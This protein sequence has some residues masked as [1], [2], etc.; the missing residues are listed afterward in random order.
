MSEEDEHQTKVT[1]NISG[2]ADTVIGVVREL[3]AHVHVYFPERAFLYI[4]FSIFTLAAIVGI[5]LFWNTTKPAFEA[6]SEGETLIIL[7]SF[8]G[9]SKD[10]E[11]D[12]RRILKDPIQNRLNRIQMA[13]GQ[14]LRMEEWTQDA[15]S[16][17]GQAKELGEKYGATLVIWGEYDD[18]IGVRTYIEIIKEV[19]QPDAQLAGVLLPVASLAPSSEQ[20]KEIGRVPLNCLSVD[21]PYQADYLTTLS[22]G[23]LQVARHE[24][25][26]AI[27][28]FSES[29]NAASHTTGDA[30]V[31][32]PHQAYYWR[33]LSYALITDYPQAKAD[34]D[35]ALA[36]FPD[37]PLALAQ[38]GNALLAMGYPADAQQDFLSGLALIYPEDSR[39]RAAL[40][41]NIGLTHELL[42][43]FDAAENYY[44]EALVL[45]QIA[46]DP[47]SLA[48]DW[49]HLGSLAIR[50]GQNSQAGE[51]F[52]KALLNYKE[53]RDG[54]GQAVVIGNQG[55]I[56]YQ[57]KDY[58]GALSNF[59]TA[60]KLCRETG[61]VNGQAVQLIRIG[62]VYIATKELDSAEKN[63]AQALALSEASGSIY[64]KAMA[65]VGLG[66]V[67]YHRGDFTTMKNHLTQAHILLNGIRSPDAAAVQQVL[68]QIE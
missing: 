13:T 34:F 52:D 18:V 55:L 65:H 49:L 8:S 44:R 17:A 60:K 3:I 47:G 23:I 36:L 58:P 42:G 11:F 67:A 41:G 57:D 26:D 40:L 45:N 68:E 10:A 21:L 5:Y 6:A 2:R 35:Q 30:C 22:M 28:F 38:R 33:G 9:G 50:R 51:Y 25:G 32:N 63:F 1:Q 4:F 12:P 29:L 64:G 31:V 27:K 7:A 39:S 15:I 56:K 19:P 20:G 53:A 24:L 66:E 37:F 61:D 62:K 59:E 46:Q 16:T 54:N 14:A 48:L 43:E